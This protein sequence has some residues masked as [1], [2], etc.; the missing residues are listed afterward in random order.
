MSEARDTSE[1]GPDAVAEIRSWCRDAHPVAPGPDDCLFCY[2]AAVVER[3]R[4]EIYDLA[5]LAIEGSERDVH[6]YVGRLAHRHQRDGLGSRL[7]G[8]PITFGPVV[9]ADESDE[10]VVNVVARHRRELTQAELAERA[11]VEPPAPGSTAW[12]MAH[13]GAG[14]RTA[15]DLMA[16]MTSEPRSSTTTDRFVALTVV[17]IE[18]ARL[19][20]EYVEGTISMEDAVEA[21]AITDTFER[22]RSTLIREATS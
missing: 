20:G 10:S 19:L 13:A 5:R 16:S 21:V 8:L 9:R 12:L 18:M 1:Q 15:A 14:S 4:T 6:L 7:F 17:A 3:H 11:G 22:L 2:A